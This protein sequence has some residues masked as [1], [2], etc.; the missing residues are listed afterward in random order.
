MK[1]IAGW[2]RLAVNWAPKLASVKLVVVGAEARLDL[3]LAP[4]ALHHGVTGE[5]L[6]GLGVD[7]AGVPPLREEPGPG[8][9]R[10]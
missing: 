4:E 7:A 2:I 8:L 3:T 1:S 5:H 6:L 10:R 9:G